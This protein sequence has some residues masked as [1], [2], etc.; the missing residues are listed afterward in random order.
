MDI[1]ERRAQKNA[2]AATLFVNL[3]LPIV[4]QRQTG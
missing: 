3:R 1:P 2:W 4:P